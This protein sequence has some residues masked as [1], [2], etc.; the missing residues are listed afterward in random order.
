[1]TLPAIMRSTGVKVHF[2]L[3]QDEDGYPPAAVESV[4]AEATDRPQ[5]FIL[6]NVPFFARA[7][8]VGDVVRTKRE[9]DAEWFDSLVKASTNSL[10]R[11]VFFDTTALDRV[12]TRLQ[13]LGCEDEYL[14][15]HTLLAVNV[16]GTA[17]MSEVRRYLDIETGSGAIDYEE[18]LL[19]AD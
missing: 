6:E 9:D 13:E 12:R 1:M 5:E 19:R 14:E 16:P 17:S 10:V 8:T 11:V 7:A 15:P 18:P 3:T 2:R 4:W